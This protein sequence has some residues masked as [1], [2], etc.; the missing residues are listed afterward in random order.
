VHPPI[1]IDG[2]PAAAQPFTDF[3]VSPQGEAIFVSYGF[4]LEHKRRR[5][6]KII[7]NKKM[8]GRSGPA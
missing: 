5:S 3:I 4:A 1:V 6:R 8:R 7:C 2:A